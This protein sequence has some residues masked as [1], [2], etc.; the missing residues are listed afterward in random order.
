MPEGYSFTDGISRDAN[1]KTW[2]ACAVSRSQSRMPDDQGVFPFRTGFHLM[3]YI[4]VPHLKAYCLTRVYMPCFRFKQFIQQDATVSQV[5]YLTFMW[6]IMFRTSP[7]PSSGAYNCTR[8]FWFYRCREAAEALLVVV[9][10]AVHYST[11]QYTTLQY[12][13]VHYPTVHYSTLQ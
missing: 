13:T 4:S 10:Q 9:C 7:R 12:S 3:Q 1:A 5:Y 8:S 11:V 2:R 6:V